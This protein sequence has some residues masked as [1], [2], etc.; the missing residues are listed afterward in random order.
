[1]RINYAEVQN[2]AV[3]LLFISE[4]V[5]GGSREKTLGRTREK[6][7]EDRRLDKFILNVVVVVVFRGDLRVKS[8]QEKG[9]K[10]ATAG[11]YE[12]FIR[13]QKEVVE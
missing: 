3:I 6:K 13:S 2:R 4:R 5:R 1:M 12:P 9:R 11:I 10:R 7:R 8:C